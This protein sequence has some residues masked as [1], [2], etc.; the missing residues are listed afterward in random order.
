MGWLVPT[1][2]SV[3][4]GRVYQEAEEALQQGTLDS[5]K[6]S[7]ATLPGWRRHVFSATRAEQD[8]SF[9]IVTLDGLELD[10]WQGEIEMR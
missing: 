3:P 8:K 1:Y 6:E 4:F 10:G 2:F 9:D 7:L 5:L